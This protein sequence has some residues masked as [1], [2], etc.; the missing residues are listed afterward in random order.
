MGRAAF[1][2]LVFL[3]TLALLGLGLVACQPMGGP[4]LSAPMPERPA[5]RSASETAF[6]RALFNR[7]QP[8]SIAENREYC[9]Y[10]ALDP[11]GNLT[12][13]PP[14]AG[15]TGHCRANDP[16]PGLVLIA[17]YHTHGGFSRDYNSETPS[18]D[19]LS[20][21]IQEGVDGYVATPGG[22]FWYNDARA[23]EAQ[24]IC[25][26]GCVVADPSYDPANHAPIAPRY[27]LNGLAALENDG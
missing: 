21:D 26:P 6:V 8:V 5:P 15:T 11:Q 17:S 4:D 23:R 12:A 18:Y 14:K 10:I 24:L 22:R 9:G 25:G 7:I 27:D 2:P 1:K 13:T 19:D 16:A 20:A 3:A